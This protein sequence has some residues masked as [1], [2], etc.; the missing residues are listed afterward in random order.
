MTKNSSKFDGDSHTRK[1]DW[2]GMTCSDGPTN[3]QFVCF[4]STIFDI[5]FHI[6][7]ALGGNGNASC[8]NSHKFFF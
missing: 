3:S 6:I 2:F 7:P 4:R 1:A 8:G 5:F